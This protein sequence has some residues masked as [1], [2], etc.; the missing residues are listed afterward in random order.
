MCAHVLDSAHAPVC[1]D[2]S[3]ND[4]SCQPDPEIQNHIPKSYKSTLLFAKPA[5]PV[6]RP[7]RATDCLSRFQ[8]SAVIIIQRVPAQL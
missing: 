8:H 2:L 1:S 4:P 6:H 3:D 5:A 7:L